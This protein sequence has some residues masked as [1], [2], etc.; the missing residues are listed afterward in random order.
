MSGVPGLIRGCFKKKRSKILRQF[1]GKQGLTNQWALSMGGYK[2]TLLKNQG[3][4]RRLLFP[5]S[6]PLH[7]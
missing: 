6:L 4:V 2:S 7:S 3:V 1:G 5:P